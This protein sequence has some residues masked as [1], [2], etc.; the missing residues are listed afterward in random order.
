[1]L[2]G[3]GALVPGVGAVA[4]RD[5]AQAFVVDAGVAT[6]VAL[7]RWCGLAVADG[8]WRDGV[9]LVALEVLV[10]LISKL[11]M[12]LV[13]MSVAVQEVGSNGRW[14][15]VWFGWKVAAIGKEDGARMV[16]FPSLA[17][18][19]EVQNLMINKMYIF[20]QTITTPFTRK[21]TL[22]KQFFFSDRALVMHKS[23]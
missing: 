14:S 9:S 13:Q 19:F 20:E 6:G 18:T 10:S 12:D 11:R 23:S 8:T 15:V 7:V 3:D 4:G 17:G 5:G 1:M 21:P 2:V 16:A 22:K